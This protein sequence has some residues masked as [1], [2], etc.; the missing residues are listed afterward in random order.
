MNKQPEKIQKLLA[1]LGFGSRR[2][3]EGL[4]SK[5]RI[6]VNGQLAKLGDRAVPEDRISIDDKLC[7]FKP[8]KNSRRILI[9]HKPEGEICTRKDTEG[10][11]T[12]FENLP[13][14][15]EGRWVLVGRLDC[16]TAGLL[17]LTT[18]GELANRLMHPSYEIEREYA[19]RVIGKISAMNIA[20]L[21]KGVRLEDGMA[22]FQQVVDA[23]GTGMNHWYHV[24]LTEGRTRE[25]RR[26]FDALDIKLNRLIRIRYGNVF[27]PRDLPKGKFRDLTDDEIAEVVNQV[28][29]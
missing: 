6:K 26:I 4:L 1:N 17:I 9:Y 19:V 27:L 20:K 8:R 15:R 7:R 18:D 14:L 5:G 11:P 24:I 12:I 28:G 21:K 16:N 25:V 29:L 13:A 3:I 22:H 10:R 23:G 2:E